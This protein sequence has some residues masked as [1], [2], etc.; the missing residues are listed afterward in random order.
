MDYRQSLDYLYRL[1]HEVLAAKYGLDGIRLLLD[2]L[3]NPERAFRSVLVAGTNGKGSTAAMIEAILRSAGQRPALYTSPHLVRIEERVRVA[4]CEI[5]E[6][7]FAKAA[8]EAQAAAE[9]MVTAGQLEATPTF[10]EHLT[11]IA[12]SFF[13]EKGAE[14]AVL[15]VGL[16]GRLDA[17]NIVS[18]LVSV[19]TAIGL[20]HESI[21]GGDVAQITA[22]KAAIIKPGSQ[23]VIS[24]Q[25]YRDASDMLMRRCIDVGVLP[26]FTSDPIGLRAESDGRLTFDYESSGGICYRGIELS[27]PGRHQVQNAAAAIETADLLRAA[28]VEIPIDAVLRGLREVEWPGRLELLQGRPR[29]LLDGAHNPDGARCLRSYLDEFCGGPVTLV[30]GAMADKDLEGIA[31]AL[32][33]VARTIVLT[34]VRDRRA[35]TGAQIGKFALDSFRNVIFTES[36]PQAISWARALTPPD[37]LI[38]VAGSLHL[39][40]EV[41]ALMV[42][43]DD[44]RAYLA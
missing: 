28:G 7:E 12:L 1:G 5:A 18:P 38:C 17:T 20:D 4:G 31:D 34:R 29:M 27:L 10:F 19:I 36:V 32:F 43:E 33:T 40:G 24:R 9:A 6:G 30:F 8:T 41:K 23:A 2:R 26:V 16:G 39:V 14:L 3:G 25:A 44:Q 35:A 22:E 21:L 13:R 37:G 11:A 42:R 15:E